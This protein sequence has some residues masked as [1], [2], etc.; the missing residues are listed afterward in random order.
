MIA[1]I[2]V[3]TSFLSVI[4]MAALAYGYRRSLTQGAMLTRCFAWSLVLLAIA[5][6]IRRGLWDILEPWYPGIYAYNPVINT[7]LNLISLVAVYFGLRA[8][9]YLIP[10]QYRREW[11][12]WSAWLHPDR[13]VFRNFYRR[14]DDQIDKE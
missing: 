12:W 2:H 10:V 11:P 9:W 14:P 5:Y 3:T 8:R 4:G 13:C 6:S 1:F 7:A